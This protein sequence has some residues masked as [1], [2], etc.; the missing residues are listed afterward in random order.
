MSNIPQLAGLK[1]IKEAYEV[2]DFLIGNV[3]YI[4]KSYL[5]V[6]I[7]GYPCIMLKSETELFPVKDYSIYLNKEI[8]VKVV[9]VQRN[10]MLTSSNIYVSHKSVAEEALEHNKFNSFDD[11]KKNHIYKGIVKD[12]KDFGLF[13]T[14]GHIDGLVHKNHLPREFT[15]TPENFVKIGAIVEVKVI[16]KDYENNQIALS[17][18]SIDPTIAD[19]KVRKKTPFEK[20]RDS[21]V[22][23]ETIVQGKVVFLE[24]EC[25]TLHVEHNENIFTVYVKKDDLAWEK[26][27]NTSDV[28]FLGEEL[29][30][31]YLNYENNKLYFDLK[32]QQ[33]DIYPQELF[34]FNTE[35]LLAKLHICEN[36]F[37]GKINLLHTVSSITENKIVSGAFANN[38]IPIG[39]SDKNT[40]LTDVFSGYDIIA[41]VP[42]K[43]TYGLKDGM[44]YTFTLKAASSIK[45]KEEHRPF[46]FIAQLDNAIP[47][48]NP[49]KELVEKSFKENKT[50][51]SNREA[52][53]YLKE[54]GADMYTDRDRMFYELLQNADDSSSVRGVKVMVQLRGNYLIFTHDG[55]SFSRQDFRSI[56]ST[57]NST[58]RLDRRKTGYKGIGFKSVFTD[59]DKV[60]IKTGGFFFMFD[61]KAQL[62]ND[63]RSFYTYVNPLY[64]EDQLEHFFEEC[65]DYEKEFEKVDHLPWQLLP[66]WVDE[67]PEELKGTTFS[68]NCN[69]A[70]ALNVGASADKYKEI[71]KGIIQKPRFM[72]FLRNTLRIQF[73]DKKWDILSIAKHFDNASNVV[74]LKNSFASNEREVSYI[75][76]KGNDV[77]VTNEAFELS[78]IPITKECQDVVGREKW[79]MYQIVDGIRIL[80]TSIPERVIAAD[81]TTLSYAFMLDE[82]NSVTCI[83][84]M[85]PALY[86]Y[87]PMEDRRYLFPFFINAD[88][89]LSSNR[90][91]AKRVS[92]WNEYLF[93]NIGKSII[94]WISLVASQ[95]HPNYLCLLPKTFFAEELEESKIDK[96]AVQFNRGYRESLSCTPFILNDRGEVVCQSDIILDESG[97]ANIIDA[98]DFCKLYGTTKRLVNRAI[99]IKPLNNTIVF[100]EIEHLQTSDLVDCILDRKNRTS[101][102]R[103]WLSISTELRNSL[104]TYIAEL[105][106]NKKNLDT[107]LC[108]IPAYTSQGKLYSF[109]RLLKSNSVVLR[110]EIVKEIERILIKLGFEIT[111]EEEVTHAFHKKIKDEIYAY[112]IHLFEIVKNRTKKDAGKLTAQE[113]SSL[114]HHFASNKMGL[115]NEELCTWEIFSNQDGEIMP[116]LGLT[117]MDSSL[118]N[119]ITKQYVIDEAEYMAV[120]KSLDRYLMKEKDQFEKIVIND[121]EGLIAEVG[122]SFEKAMSLYSLVSTTYTVAEHEQAEDKNINPLCDKNC[123]FVSG[124]MHKL[125]NVIINSQLARNENIVPII[126]TLTGKLVPNIDV[127]GAVSKV[128]F[129]CREQQLSNLILKS[130]VIVNLEQINLLLGYCLTQKDTIFNNYYII[131]TEDGYRFESITK[132]QCIAFTTN[133]SLCAFIEQNCKNIILLQKEFS[134]YKNISEILT[135]ED[136]LLKI[137]EILGDVKPYAEQLLPIYRNS[138][139]LIKTSYISHLSSIVM[140]ENSFIDDSDINLQT[141]LLASTIEKQDDSLFEILRAMMFVMSDDVTHKFNSI[142]LQHTIEVDSQKFPLSKLVPNED[143]V[144]MLVDT[145]KERLE[146]KHLEQN[147][148]DRLFGNEIDEGR[149]NEVFMTLNNS[150][151][152]LENGVQLAFIIKYLESK[153]TTNSILCKVLDT[154]TNPLSHYISSS[155]FLNRED[156]VDCNHIL[157]TQYIDVVK[158][159][160]L[161]YKNEKIGCCIRKDIDDYQF[162]K[163]ILTEEEIIALLNYVLKQYEGEIKLSDGDIQHIKNSIRLENKEYVVSSN[164]CLPSE[165]LPTIVEQWR[166]SSNTERKNKLLRNIFNIHFDDSDAVKVRRFLVEGILFSLETKNNIVSKMTCDWIYEKSLYL[167]NIQYSTIV[168]ILE[169]KDY[170]WEINAEKLSKFQSSECRY[171]V[172]GD[173]YVYLCEGAI[174]W[175]VRLAETGYIFHS[176]QEKDI[177]LDGYNIFVNHRKKQ[178]ILD[179]VRSLINTDGFTAE[180]FMLFYDQEKSEMSVSLD[181]EIDDDIDEETREAANQLAKQE[182]IDWLSSKGYNTT[183]VRT[184]YSFIDGVCKD[185]IEYNIVVKSFRSTSREL[186]INP[187][188]WLYLLKANSRLMLYMGHMSFA[189]VDRKSLLGNHDFLR[190]RISS[191]NFSVENNKLDEN[192]ERLARDIQYF[193]RTHFVLERIHDNILSRANSLDDYGLFKSNSNYEYSAGN[194]EDIE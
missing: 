127:I 61:K 94:S 28:V 23:N 43:Y 154:S 134:S 64:T 184:N 80:I 180:D 136:L 102:L 14:L 108:D 101:I 66:F 20:F 167:E 5:I 129:S 146:E 125:I 118:Y 104:L 116:I 115:K 144:A 90:Q 35:E 8:V 107:Q 179:L 182:A 62:F 185:N 106:R 133:E 142:N 75:V 56:V 194:E 138:I 83:P 33:K 26:V 96:L 175:N 41:Y 169:D 49:Y 122:Y 69:V 30:V 149:A 34:S 162:V 6:K 22:T 192:L 160:N 161:P 187:N 163:N 15:E 40:Q 151:V 48:E 140:D 54:I 63:F 11:I 82:N 148:I 9:S 65:S 19:S 177:I 172:F 12:Y 4:G 7:Y 17:I 42:A 124:E 166:T 158:Y 130:D 59:S 137:L 81:T 155:W 131:E 24:K 25:V 128:P 139:S 71:I 145:L 89:E 109:N 79:Y 13:V 1:K 126:E 143:K 164:Y 88:F 52:A 55:L 36:K 32:W 190:L 2:Q 44:Y 135:E 77:P 189:V 141:L 47:I 193:E 186:K 117:H 171:S 3:S 103:Y 168:D 111:E 183:K 112:T 21:L 51:K 176:Y 110:I 38:L 50:P 157:A 121:W 174:P 123:I 57:A 153:K 178:S 78:G 27:Q 73:E 188:E 91:E 85:T 95:S 132:G 170:I 10:E 84:N 39:I 120:G 60:Y 67:M 72:L 70:I 99:N 31:K 76:Q 100:S 53:N 181:G 156:F 97:F 74:T 147:F 92:V 159:I 105:P 173:Y 119:D 165:V 46:M 113:K 29:K 114:F 93:Y 86:A 191:S 45:R 152:I 98:D 150:D 16:Y 18:P 68:R 58:K 37:V 87:L